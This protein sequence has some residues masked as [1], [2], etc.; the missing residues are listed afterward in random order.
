V[1]K[2]IVTREEAEAH[3]AMIR[4][5]IEKKSKLWEA[6]EKDQTTVAIALGYALPDHPLNAIERKR[7][8][9]RA[10]QIVRREL[11]KLLEGQEPGPDFRALLRVWVERIG[12]GRGRTNAGIRR[13]LIVERVADEYRKYHNHNSRAQKILDEIGEKLGVR[14]TGKLRVLHKQVLHDV[15]AQV[16][17]DM[18]SM[19]RLAPSG[20]QTINRAVQRISRQRKR[21]ERSGK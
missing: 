15:G 6:A 18:E 19:K 4:E 13:A 12:R 5:F 20:V 11:L 14:I 8:N 7:I 17:L 3:D 9:K 21:G 1:A 2:R 16:G 10:D